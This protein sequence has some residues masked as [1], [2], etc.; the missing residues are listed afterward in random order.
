MGMCSFVHIMQHMCPGQPVQITATKARLEK[1][2]KTVG[3][4]GSSADMLIAQCA[5]A[6]EHAHTRKNSL[7]RLSVG[8]NLA[9]DHALLQIT[10]VALQGAS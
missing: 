1:I 3:R 8:T 6:S 5:S 7:F 10:N 2:G 9:T 4:A